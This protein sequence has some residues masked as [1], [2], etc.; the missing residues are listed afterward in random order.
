MARINLDNAAKYIH[1]SPPQALD[2]LFAAVE[3]KCK[4]LG[5]EPGRRDNV[6]VGAGGDAGGSVHGILRFVEQVSAITDED[7][8]EVTIPP[9]DEAAAGD[10]QSV[11]DAK[12]HRRQGLVERERVRKNTLEQKQ[13]DHEA[14]RKLYGTLKARFTASGYSPKKPSGVLA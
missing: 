9:E 6:G 1:N 8:T 13:A 12:Y 5:L 11:L 7:K 14:L 10:A 4:A 3:E 2:G